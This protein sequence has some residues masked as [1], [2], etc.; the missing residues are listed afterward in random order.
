MVECTDVCAGDEEIVRRHVVH[1]DVAQRAATDET[2]CKS[3]QLDIRDCLKAP[4]PPSGV[5]DAARLGS[6]GGAWLEQHHVHSEAVFAE[7]HSA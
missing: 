7:P 6:L 1:F 2:L 5:R 3:I 4:V